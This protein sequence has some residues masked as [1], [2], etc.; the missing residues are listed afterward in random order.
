MTR[1]NLH[2]TVRVVTVVMVLPSPL[3]SW[4]SD[5]SLPKVV[6]NEA[7]VKGDVTGD[8]AEP[9]LPGPVPRASA[10]FELRRCSRPRAKGVSL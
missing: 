6:P 7:R 1:V 4:I 2:V 3:M 5:A 10:S 8:V 9:L